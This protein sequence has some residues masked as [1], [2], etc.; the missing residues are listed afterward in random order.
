MFQTT[1]W[2]GPVYH[3]HAKWDLAFALQA[4]WTCFFVDTLKRLRCNNAYIITDPVINAQPQCVPRV[5]ISLLFKLLKA[6]VTDST[7]CNSLIICCICHSFILTFSLN[8]EKN[9]KSPSGLPVI[10]LSC[11]TRG[12][13][14]LHNLVLL[15]SAWWCFWQPHLSSW[16]PFWAIGS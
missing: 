16:Q 6:A 7:R 3:L 2:E 14:Q 11:K 4:V 5:S 15:C 12:K 13:H 9:H 1:L 10:I 8:V